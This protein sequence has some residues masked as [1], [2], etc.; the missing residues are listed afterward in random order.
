MLTDLGKDWA[1][2]PPS[3]FN[4]WI[5]TIYLVQIALN[6]Y[7]IRTYV[8]DHNIIDYPQIVDENGT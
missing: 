3:N 4:T 7:D 5:P 2:G 6:R 1:S 8:N